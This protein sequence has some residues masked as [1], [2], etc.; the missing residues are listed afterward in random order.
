MCSIVTGHKKE[1]KKYEKSRLKKTCFFHAK[2]QEDIMKQKFKRWMAGL[3]AV[4]TVFTSLFANGTPAFAA[5]A[6]ANI[7]FWYASTKD[8]G[9]VSELKAG[10]SHGKVLYAMID[11][12]S[13]Y[14]MNFGLAA[15]GGQ[16]MNSYDN[17]S[18]SLTDTQALYLR[19]C[20]YYG[21]SSTSTSAPSNDQCDQYIATQSMVWIIEKGIYGTASADSAAKKL[22]D[23]APNPTASYQYYATLKSNIDAGINAVIPSIAASRKS[24]APTYE[25]KWNE[26]N[27]RFETTLT[28]SNGVLSEFDLSLSGYSTSRNGN[29]LTIYS[30]EVNTSATTGTFTSNS[31]K[32]EVTG[33]CVFWLTGNSGDQEFV[34][35]VPH[36]D[37]LPAYI[38]VKTENIGYGELYKKDEASGVNL[39][40]A[41]YGIY[42]DSSCKNLVQTITTDKNGYAKSG[43][44]VAG[45]YYMKEITAPNKYV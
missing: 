4:L 27:Q 7:S 11:G 24:Q 21:F 25:L 1:N 26:T 29:S 44:L 32:V 28:D 42:F 33:S 34:S 39:A 9:E 18:T 6:S 2:N 8:S 10:Y 36:G 41:V 40:G 20:L 13:A 17:S 35:E 16:L 22:C 30:S 38:K 15:K 14:C 19:Y 45:T 5:S 3:L 37:P 23:T 31:G 43:A 12:H